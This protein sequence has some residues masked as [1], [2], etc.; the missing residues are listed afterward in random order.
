[1]IEYAI[2]DWLGTR[3]TSI[4]YGDLNHKPDL[5]NE[6]IRY[7]EEGGLAFKHNAWL[8]LF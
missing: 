2:I 6:I 8:R 5:L 1:M 7:F 3:I 4:L